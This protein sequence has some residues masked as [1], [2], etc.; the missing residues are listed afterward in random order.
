MSNTKLEPGIYKAYHH[1]G[2]THILIARD[3]YNKEYVDFALNGT[4]QGVFPIARIDK[5]FQ[6]YK[7]IL[8]YQNPFQKAQLTDW[9][10][11]WNQNDQ[12]HWVCRAPRIVEIKNSEPHVH[13]EIGLNQLLEQAAILQ[14]EYEKDLHDREREQLFDRGIKL[15]GL[16]EGGQYAGLPPEDR[17]ALRVVLEV[18]KEM[19]K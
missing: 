4:N 17:E 10:E 19:N 15:L 5:R 14:A 16:I 13:S 18:A 1:G 12:G 11:H 7:K 3:G 6:M 8:P 9:R 2:T